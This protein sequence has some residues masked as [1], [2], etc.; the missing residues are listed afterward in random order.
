MDHNDLK[1][2]L[3][4]LIDEYRVLNR[5]LANAQDRQAVMQQMHDNVRRQNVLR[6]QLKQGE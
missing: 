3:Q 5:N 1:A 2:Q 4:V 6:E